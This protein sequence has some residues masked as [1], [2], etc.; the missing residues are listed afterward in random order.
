MLAWLSGMRC[1]LAYSPLPLTIF[2][3]SKSRLV[4]T[5]LVLPFRW[6]RTYS[7]R[8]V[9]RLCV[10]V[11]WWIFVSQFFLDFFLHL[12]RKKPLG[13]KRHR[14]FTGWM[15]FLSPSKQC[16]IS[17][18]TKLLGL[19]TASECTYQMFT[20]I[21][22]YRVGA[23]HPIEHILPNPDLVV[24]V[25]KGSKTLLQQDTPILNWVQTNT[26]S[27]VW[28]TKWLCVYVHLF[29]TKR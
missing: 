7:R 9:K 14:F 21:Q 16:H 20:C 8:A 17:F 23:S 3:S 25:S 11:F 26:A 18:I 27:P 28:A 15:H 1:R 19:N 5:F 24:T 29:E 4:L 6:S 2:C 22:W 12:F 10:C 13:R